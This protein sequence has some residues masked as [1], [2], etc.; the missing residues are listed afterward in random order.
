MGLL[1]WLSEG[2]TGLGQGGSAMAAPMQPPPMP[3]GNGVP[4]VESAPLPDVPMDGV[5]A[6]PPPVA[7]TPPQIAPTPDAPPNV[8]DIMQ[9]YARAGGNPMMPPVQQ[10]TGGGGST[11]ILENAL[12]LSPDRARQVRSSLASGLKAVGENW[13]KPGLA[14]L[15]GTAGS[16]MEGGEKREDKTTDQRSKLLTQMIAAQAAG[17]KAAYNKNYMAYLKSKQENETSKAARGSAIAPEKLYLDVKKALATDPEIVAARHGLEA[18]QRAGDPKATASAQ[19]AFDTILRRK[20]TEAF[21]AVKL[22]PKTAADLEKNPPGSKS[23]PLKP[24]SKAELERY[25]EPGQLYVNPADG[26]TYVYKG[27]G[28]KMTGSA[29]APGSPAEPPGPMPGTAAMTPAVTPT[30]E[31]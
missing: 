23:N 27:G 16:A 10:S 31:D 13:N 29:A 11:G 17:D 9:S 2:L 7:Q 26:K 19:A 18:A 20:Q 4:P 25:A 15:S 8:P 30:D 1:D 24:T 5:P 3:G 12:G 14:A 21:A 28:G 6:V 22:N